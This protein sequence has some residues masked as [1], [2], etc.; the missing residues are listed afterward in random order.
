MGIARQVGQILDMTVGM[1]WDE[2][3]E[4]LAD[5]N[6]LTTQY[7]AASGMMPGSELG[8]GIY[9]F[10][11]SMKAIHK[12]GEKFSYVAPNTDL[13][14]YILVRVS[15]V[16]NISMARIAMQVMLGK[17]IP[18]FKLQH[19]SIP[20]YGIKEAVFPF[21]M[22]SEVDPILGPEMRSTGEVLGISHSYGRSFFKIPRSYSVSTTFRRIRAFYYCGSRQKCGTGSGQTF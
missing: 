16:C 4:A 21:N 7:A 13:A 17:R 5:P 22:F 6:T 2:S 10:L 3:S 18:D 14:C 20:H 15:K 9:D 1:D 11:P 19:Q 12:H 8:K